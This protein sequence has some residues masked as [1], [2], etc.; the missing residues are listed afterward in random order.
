MTQQQQASLSIRLAQ[1][2]H[3]LIQF[4]EISFFYICFLVQMKDAISLPNNQ[5]CIIV[6]LTYIIIIIKLL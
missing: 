2:N 5:S 1:I 6:D 3:M 4:I